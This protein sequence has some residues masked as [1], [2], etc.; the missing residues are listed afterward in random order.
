MA[1]EDLLL[2]TGK[3]FRQDPWEIRFGLVGIHPSKK[4]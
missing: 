2:V 4:G 3:A 1:F